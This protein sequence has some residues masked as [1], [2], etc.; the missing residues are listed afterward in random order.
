MLDALLR[1]VLPYPRRRA[2]PPHDGSATRV[3]VTRVLVTGSFPNPTFDYFLKARLAGLG[4]P[5]ILADRRAPWPAAAGD[6]AGTAV[7]VCRY[8]HPALA[9]YVRQ[10][11]PRLAGCALLIDDDV[12]AIVADGTA[13]ARYRVRMLRQALLPWQALSGEFDRLFAANAVLRARIGADAE[14]LGPLPDPADATPRPRAPG[15]AVRM[16]F[17]ATDI[18]AGEHAFLIPVVDRVLRA[19]PALSMEV[20]AGDAVAKAWAGLPRTTVVPP[21]SWPAFRDHTYETGADIALV[22]LLPTA[23]N[24]ARTA[25]KKIDVARLGAAGLFARS[26]AYGDGTDTGEWMLGP[27]ADAWHDAIL[28]LASDPARRTALAAA[29]RRAVARFGEGGPSLL[30][31]G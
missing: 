12:H 6:G 19:L 27:S 17:H 26:D 15:G 1:A 23:V 24:R 11:R 30:L 3:P 5:V 18:H 16:V 2:G 28:A 21:L 9:A 10:N 20:V 7:I 13:R 22:P 31:S 8:P 25:T 29:T 4:L 14:V